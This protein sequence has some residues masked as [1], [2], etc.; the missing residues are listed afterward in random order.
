MAALLS[1]LGNDGRRKRLLFNYN[2][3]GSKVSPPAVEIDHSII[4]FST[5]A[6]RN[7]EIFEHNHYST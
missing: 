2:A 4:V 6:Q 5:G 1:G 3:H 7:G